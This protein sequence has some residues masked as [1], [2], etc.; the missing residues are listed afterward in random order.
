M[1]HS[2]QEQFRPWRHTAIRGIGMVVGNRDREVGVVGFVHD[3]TRAACGGSGM[4][5]MIL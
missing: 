3:D 1:L 5:A 4:G 2:G